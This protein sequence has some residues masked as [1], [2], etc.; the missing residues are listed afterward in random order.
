[1]AVSFGLGKKVIE[2]PSYNLGLA[3]PFIAAFFLLNNAAPLTLPLVGYE[4][5]PQISTLLKII[6]VAIVYAIFIFVFVLAGGLSVLSPE[7]RWRWAIPG[8]LIVFA[9][10]TFHANDGNPKFG[11][12][13]VILSAL[14]VI[15]IK[16]DKGQLSLLIVAGTGLVI[17]LTCFVAGILWFEDQ[18]VFVPAIQGIFGFASLTPESL[19][20]G[21]AMLITTGY[22]MFYAVFQ[23]SES[24]SHLLN[25]QEE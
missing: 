2:H 12:L 13:F 18:F 9:A 14:Y 24:W 8:G 21:W 25:T 15:L 17:A 1:M 3:L 10:L 19:K 23:T 4:F 7:S 11:L 6:A 5:G 22:S 20:I 16:A